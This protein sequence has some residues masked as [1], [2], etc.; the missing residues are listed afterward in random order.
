MHPRT[1]PSAAI[2]ARYSS[3]FQTD[4]SIDDQLALCADFARR[5]GLTVQ[6][7][8]DDRA[9]SAASIMERDGLLSMM[10]AA[11]AG[12]FDVLIV[13]AR[14]R[15]SRDQEDLTGIYSRLP[16]AG[17]ENR[18]VHEGRTDI[19]R[20]GIRG[21]VGALYL[22]DLAHKVRPGMA[23]VVR[24]GRKAYFNAPSSIPMAA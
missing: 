11:R 9:L 16:H 10:D 4:P 14:D 3:D 22:R 2:Y 1:S 17:I 7:T 23:G 24:D 5:L 13:E 6:A 19:I 15:L 20:I 8:F 18:A 21:L 12:T